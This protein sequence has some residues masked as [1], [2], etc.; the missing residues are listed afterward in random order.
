[1]KNVFFNDSV[2]QAEKKIIAELEIPSLLLMEN[3]GANS[4]EYLTSNY[5][6]ILINGVTVVSGKG[7]NAG[8][9]FVLARQL[10]L[11]KNRVKVIMLFEDKELK[12]D[13]LINF[14]V[15]KNLNCAGLKIVYCKSPG[16]V[17]KELND[18]SKIIVDAI[19]GIGFSGKPDK[20]ITE[21]IS[22]LNN[23]SNKIIISLD[24]PSCLNHYNQDFSSVKANVTLSMGVRKFHSMFYKGREYSGK[25]ET[26]NI[27]IPEEEFDKFNSEGIYITEIEDVK[28]II[29]KRKFDSN[30]Y[31]NGKV[32]ILTG[33]PGLTGASFLA[34]MSA[35]RAGVGAVIAGIPESLNEIMEEKLTEV[36][37]LPL[38]ETDES[39]LSLGA[40]PEIKKK[41]KWA[42]V[43]LIGPGISKNEETSEL[44]RKIVNEIE[45]KF[46]IDADGIYAFG[47]RL[48]L[49][50]GKDII[51]TPHYGEFS[52]LTGITT[53]ELKND[54][55]NISK[56]FAGKYRLTL[57]LKNA[58]SAVT[59]GKKFLINSTGRENLATAGSGDVLS[60]ITAA[61]FSQ[62]KNSLQSAAAAAFVHGYCGDLLYEKYGQDGAIAG[63]L[64]DEIRKVKFIINTI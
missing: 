42:D 48:N 47:D 54:F 5:G 52:S 19:F 45:G 10:C 57:L 17:K 2:L 22:I 4:S 36:M 46:I 12:G 41:I 18:D 53:D 7:N 3:A 6:E 43:T 61:Y 58:P 33:S 27:G 15:L 1:M 13:A 64:I 51:L 26:V 21:I 34:S 31:S 30:K 28:K 37:T 25:T 29:P 11:R 9:G 38:K 32:F 63:D 40:F 39:T 14:N 56:E 8:D 49:L 44:V 20:R 50:K 23:L 16:D 24:T 55:F 62:S 35:L 60:G 59:D